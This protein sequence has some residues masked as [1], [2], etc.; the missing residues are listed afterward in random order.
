MREDVKRSFQVY[1]GLFRRYIDDPLWAPF[2]F[3]W[4]PHEEGRLG[5]AMRLRLMQ[6]EPAFEKL[7]LKV[8]YA[9]VSEELKDRMLRAISAAAQEIVTQA[10]FLRIPPYPGISCCHHGGQGFSVGI[11]GPLYQEGG[12]PKERFRA[13]RYF[14]LGRRLEEFVIHERKLARPSQRNETS[15]EAATLEQIELPLQGN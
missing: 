7:S 12:R 3:P 6:L 15:H 13:M 14:H 4:T 1:E 2:N 11:K 8:E 9:G 5:G 10:A